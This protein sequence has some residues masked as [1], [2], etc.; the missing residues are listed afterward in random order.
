[1]GPANGWSKAKKYVGSDRMGNHSDG[2]GNALMK[3]G[4]TM[5]IDSDVELATVQ[6]ELA[7]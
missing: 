1:M 2:G 4:A 5:Q 6:S 3:N 7:P